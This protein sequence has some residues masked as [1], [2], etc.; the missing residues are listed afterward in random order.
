MWGQSLGLQREKVEKNLSFS[1]REKQ[2]SFFPDA[3]PKWA[4]AT[5]YPALGQPMLFPRSR[6]CSWN[7][8]YWHHLYFC[9]HSLEG[10][11]LEE[12]VKHSVSTQLSPTGAI[13][14]SAGHARNLSV[15]EAFPC[16]QFDGSTSRGSNCLMRFMG[17]CPP[18]LGSSSPCFSSPSLQGSASKVSG[19]YFLSRV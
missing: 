8:L 7:S 16:W 9:S 13:L 17:L 6:T 14:S 15:L 10:R 1:Y 2:P 4:S 19:S 12:K 11:H 3:N 5:S 18:L